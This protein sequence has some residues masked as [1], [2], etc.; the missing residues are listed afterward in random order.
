M[1]IILVSIIIISSSSSRSSSK[2]QTGASEHGAA[3]SCGESENF[4]YEYHSPVWRRYVY[5]GLL[6][7][8]VARRPP[9]CHAPS[10]NSRLRL[11]LH[12]SVCTLIATTY[13]CVYMCVHM[14]IYIYIYTYM[15]IH[16]YTHSYICIAWGRSRHRLK[17]EVGFITVAG[18]LRE[19]VFRQQA[20][21]DEYIAPIDP[22]LIHRKERHAQRNKPWFS[23]AWYSA[24]YED[25][26]AHHERHYIPSRTC[27]YV[28][29]HAHAHANVCASVHAH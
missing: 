21:S 7:S 14:S 5:P 10:L 12:A 24:T 27:S 28:C 19:S 13:I 18:V 22:T 17:T 11:C 16:I 23:K 2:P 26:Y 4:G 6:I 20:A 29:E 15:Y 3:T 25:R 1:N 9:V 8:L